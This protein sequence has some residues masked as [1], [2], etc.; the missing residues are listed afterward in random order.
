VATTRSTFGRTVGGHFVLNNVNCTGNESNIFDCQYPV[1][2]RIDCLVVRNQE[3][4][5][6]CGVTQGI[7]FHSILMIIE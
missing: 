6:I 5:V 7:R 1:N 3:A 2:G 4:G